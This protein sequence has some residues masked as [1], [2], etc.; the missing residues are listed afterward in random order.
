M[1]RPQTGRSPNNR[2]SFADDIGSHLYEIHKM[3]HLKKMQVI[4][5]QR[6]VIKQKSS[7]PALVNDVSKQIVQIKLNQSLSLIFDTLDR[8]KSGAISG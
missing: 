3:Q 7:T 8:N 5:H 6:E 1:F 4:E 2:S